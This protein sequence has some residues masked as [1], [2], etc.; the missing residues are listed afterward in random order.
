MEVDCGDFTVRYC[1]LL[2]GSAV[3][4]DTI[5][6]QGDVIGKAGKIPCESAQ[7]NHVHIEI[8]KD[9]DRTDFG[10]LAAKK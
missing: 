2:Q 3:K 5:I 6:S 1:G 4:P 9:G 7:E 8:L 10:D